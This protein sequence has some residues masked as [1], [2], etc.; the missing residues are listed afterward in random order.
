MRRYGG[1]S[2]PCLGLF[3]L[4]T[5]SSAFRFLL[6]LA[7]SLLC[8]IERVLL[9]RDGSKTDDGLRSFVVVQVPFV[10]TPPKDP[11]HVKGK[12][13]SVERVRQIKDADGNLKVEWTYVTVLSGL[14]QIIYL[15]LGL[16]EQHGHCF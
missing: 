10:Q 1:R 15:T 9:T 7:Q 14:R 4:E 16:H 13:I 11:K 2:I 8:G 6:T 3:I 5:L 12:Y